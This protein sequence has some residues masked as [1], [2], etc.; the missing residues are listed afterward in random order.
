M[1]HP[2]INFDKL[3]PIDRDRL[4]RALLLG[5]ARI[6]PGQYRVFNPVD[7]LKAPHYV[8]LASSDTPRCDCG[9]HEYRDMLC[10]HIIA[11]LLAD[12]NPVAAE[13]LA[14][15]MRTRIRG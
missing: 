15:Y 5:T 6:G 13:A 7:P 1:T 10:K 8:D 12:N 9:D 11:A 3:K 4:S 14:E 2:P